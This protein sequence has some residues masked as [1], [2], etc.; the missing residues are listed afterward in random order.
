MVERS[1]LNVVVRSTR[2]VVGR[3]TL[4]VVERSCTYYADVVVRT[5]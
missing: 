3:C 1:T 4:S 5:T 2:Y